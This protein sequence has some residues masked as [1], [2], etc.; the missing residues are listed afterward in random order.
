MSETLSVF[1]TTLEATG[2]LMLGVWLLSLA[3]KD[4]SIVDIFWGLGFVLIAVV[5]YSTT[6][7]YH[8]RKLLV[9]V[10]TTIWGLRLAIHIL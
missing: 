7:G 9:T 8:D 4:A 3:M 6:N 10:L 1:A 2:A 5:C